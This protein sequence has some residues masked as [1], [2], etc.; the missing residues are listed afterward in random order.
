MLLTVNERFVL[1]EILPREGSFATLK[2]VRKLRE[3]L[4]FT[5]QELKDF[6]IKESLLP[7]GRVSIQWDNTKVKDAPIAIGEKATDIIVGALKKLDQDGK[8][9]DR[10]YSL[11]GKFIGE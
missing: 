9:T 4:S 2:I 11:Y 3:S 10:E 1:L 5:E 7:D 8:L 6:D